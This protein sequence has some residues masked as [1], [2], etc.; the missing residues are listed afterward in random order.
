MSKTAGPGP[1]KRAAPNRINRAVVVQAGLAAFSAKGFNGASMRDIA[2][3]ARTSLSN[4]YNYFP[5][6]SYLL[7]QILLDTGSDLHARLDAAVQAADG[8]PAERL[9]A[10]VDAYVGFIVDRPL[11]SV[12]GISEI[13]YVDGANRQEVTEV[14]DR[15]D[16][17]FRHIV[18]EGCAAGAFGTEFPREAARA[19]V[20]MCSA[21]STWY[22]PDGALGRAELSERYVRFSLGIVQAS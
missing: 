16:N 12:I 8:G 7:A 9:S 17:L 15:T 19:I 5:S 11:A 6:K 10:A 14:R 3:E 2:A 20:T 21:M 13:R 18:D 1:T 22:R 4:L